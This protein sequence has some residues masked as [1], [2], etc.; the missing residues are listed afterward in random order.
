MA[1]SRPMTLVSHHSLL[2]ARKNSPQDMSDSRIPKNVGADHGSVSSGTWEQVID[3]SQH[4]ALNSPVRQQ[5]NTQDVNLERR[6]DL[7]SST[8]TWEQVRGSETHVNSPEVEFCDMQNQTSD[9]MSKVFQILQQKFGAT[10]ELPKCAM[11]ACKTNI[12]MSVLIMS[13]PMKAAIHV[14]PS[15]T[16]NLADILS[17]SNSH[18]THLTAMLSPVSPASSS[19]Q[20]SSSSVQ[21]SRMGLSLW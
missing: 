7:S 17:F 3:T 19:V 15:Y 11:E 1:K 12:L 13:S 6:R 4:S 14:D 9:Y 2:S 21:S 10:Q 8:S 20:R 16:D 18:A 5:E